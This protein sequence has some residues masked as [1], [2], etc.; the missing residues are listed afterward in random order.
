MTPNKAFM[1]I[2]QSSDGYEWVDVRTASGAHDVCQ[3]IA[4]KDN[5]QLPEWAKHN[6]IVRIAAMTL[7]E[8]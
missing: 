7:T 6:K 4:D 2:R 3:Q 1:A 8:N 5:A